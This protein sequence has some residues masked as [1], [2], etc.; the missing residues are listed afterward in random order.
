MSKRLAHER[1]Y[2]FHCQILAKQFPNAKRLTE[3]FEISH[4]QAQRDIEFMRER[5]KAPL[6]YISDRRGYIYDEKSSY[7]FPP[8]W[9]DEEELLAFFLALRLASTLPDRSLK[10]SLKI[11]LQRFLAFRSSDTSIGLVDME[12][13]VSVKNIQYYRVDEMVFHKTINSLFRSLP[14]SV[15]YFM[16]IRKRV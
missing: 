10:N 14:G 6:V 9:L 4:K 2:W 1:F 15:T 8:V 3:H 13:K 12:K 11:F 16:Q 7:E 5:L